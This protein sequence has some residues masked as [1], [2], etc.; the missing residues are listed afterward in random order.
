MMRNR[1]WLLAFS[2]LLIVLFG[3]ILY[4]PFL[5]NGLVFDDHGFFA[6]LSIYDKAVIPFNFRPRTFPYFTLGFIQVLYGSLEANRI[7]SLVLHLSCC[8]LLFFLLVSLLEQAKR[9]MVA[10]PGRV[11]PDS[12]EVWMLAT[13]G[14]MWFT[15]HPIAVYGA[16]YLAQRTILFATLFSLLSLWFYQR[17][18][19]KNSISD[20]FVAAFFYSMAVF[21]KEHAVMLPL[22]AVAL[23]VLYDGSFQ[24]HLK[25]IATYLVLCLPAALIVIFVA[26]HVVATSYEPNVGGMIQSMQQ[27]IPIMSHSWGQWLVSIVMQAGF[28]FSYVALWSVPNVDMLSA[29]MR[30]DFVHVWFSWWSFPAAISFVLSPIVAVYFLRK[31]GMVALFCCGFLYS[32]IL[33][34]TELA[35]IRF[36]E[37]FVLYRSYIWAPGYAMMLVAWYACLPR[38]WLVIS[39]VPVLIVF[40]FLARER[41]SS[42]ESDTTIWKDAASKL[43]S[44]TILGSDRIFYN[45]G[46]AYL[47]EKN[48]SSAIADYSRVITQNPKFT[49]AYYNRAL[50]YNASEKYEKARKDVEK[51][52]ELDPLNGAAYYTLGFLLEK[53]GSLSAAYQ[54]YLKSAARGNWMAKMKIVKIIKKTD[55]AENSKLLN[56]NLN[57]D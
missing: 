38:R 4:I 18:C 33:F 25:K 37:P 28:F 41:L 13:F 23:T 57:V 3:A 5:S 26:K 29:D 55:E 9:M 52:L 11:I 20:V 6:N 22:A 46:N 53:Q 15:I 12:V 44:Q 8:C 17:A 1:R 7:F 54:A 19:R 47:T 49:E 32:W 27:V 35:A 56:Q 10:A 43:T 14:A 39:A 30:F 50:A 2:I 36:Q 24:S 42:F 34:L 48:Y 16:A 31:K 40:I 45:R 51:T 21:S